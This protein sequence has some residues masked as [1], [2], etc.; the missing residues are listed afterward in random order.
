VGN[1]LSPTGRGYFTTSLSGQDVM[2]DFVA[3]PEP[4]TR[5]MALTG[6]ACGGYVVRRRRKRD[7]RTPANGCGLRTSSARSMVS[8]GIA[9]FF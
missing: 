8:S 6:L 4:S 2:L 3:V 5:A 9:M 1:P 7:C